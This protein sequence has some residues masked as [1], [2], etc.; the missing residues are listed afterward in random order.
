MDIMFSSCENT[1]LEDSGQ[2]A[3]SLVL[4]L[5]LLTGLWFNLCLDFSKEKMRPP[6]MFVCVFVCLFLTCSLKYNTCRKVHIL[7][8]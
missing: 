1:E 7:S 6:K 5:P 8:I 2:A 3:Q 4:F